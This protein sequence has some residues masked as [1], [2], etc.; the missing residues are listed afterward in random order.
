MTVVVA[1]V[2]IGLLALIIGRVRLFHGWFMVHGLFSSSYYRHRFKKSMYR[3][4]Y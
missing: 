3:Y 4:M 2:E 1:A